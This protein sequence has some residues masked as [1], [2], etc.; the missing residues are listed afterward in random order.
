MEPRFII[1]LDHGDV[2]V[3][4]ADALTAVEGHDI[5]D[6]AAY[7]FS[8]ERLELRLDNGERLGPHTRYCPA[9]QPSR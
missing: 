8:G 6:N 1:S 5:D 7:S 2:D 3:D 4:P 9:L